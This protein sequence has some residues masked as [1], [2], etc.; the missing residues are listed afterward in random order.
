MPIDMLKTAAEDITKILEAKKQR[1]MP[2]VPDDA[3]LAA[4]RDM[5]VAQATNA[6]N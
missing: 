4:A 6:C 5:L 2:E 3:L 1:E